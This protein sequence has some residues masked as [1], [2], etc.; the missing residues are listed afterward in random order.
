LLDDVTV[1]TGPT[2][3]LADAM[4]GRGRQPSYR[5]SAVRVLR[6]AWLW[7]SA[8]M[9]VLGLWQIGRPEMWQDELVTLGV[10]PRPWRHIMSLLSHVDA[11]HGAYYLFMHGWIRAF[12]DSPA[13]IRVPSALAMVGAAA[14][15]GLIGQRIFGRFAGLLGGLVFALVPA[16]SRFAQE[17][18]SYAFVILFAALA[19]LLLLRAIDRSTLWRWVGYAFCVTAVMF[20]NAVALSLIVGHGIGV[21]MWSGRRWN[22]RPFLK[23]LGAAL[24]GVL[25]AS[26]MIYLGV[27][28]ATTQVVWIP[29]DAPWAV[30]P[31]AFASSWIAWTV[32]ALAALALV[33][34]RSRAAFATAVAVLPLLVIWL[35][36]LGV[37]S[38]FFSKYLLFLLPV[39]AVLAGAGLTVVRWR[40][41]S[42]AGLAVLAAIA[43]P[44]QIAMR[45]R[46]SHS[47]YTYPDRRPLPPLDYAA[48]AKIIADNYEPGDGIVYQRAQYWW[49]M[50]DVAIPFYLP[51][52][53]KPRDIFL[54]T[55][56]DKAYALNTIDCFVAQLCVGFERRVWVVIPY[57]TDQAMEKFQLDQARA[58]NAQYTQAW[59]KH[60]SGMTV[61]LLQRNR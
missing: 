44:D 51:K 37:I 33:R 14:C 41:A 9:A 28:Q 15:V 32:T 24:V 23:F 61:A 20:F 19:T 2:S 21:L 49:Y 55:S 47:W 58:L 31:R 40:T 25:P 45:G 57:R 52:D 50:H 56:A 43:I 3:S 26:P 39:W 46:L 11:V 42:I 1:G 27:Q 36:S 4:A 29:H 48:A 8:F 34:Y 30:W 12:G 16:A 22:W 53:V 17:V 60:P 35:A 54:Q 10:A 13:S 5:Q 38:Y 6:S 18:R 7:P 59:V